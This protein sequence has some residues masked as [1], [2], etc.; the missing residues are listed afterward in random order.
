MRIIPPTNIDPLQTDANGSLNVNVVSSSAGGSATEAAG[1]D[2]V[3]NTTT[4]ALTAT[5]LSSFNG[6]TWDRVRS[7][8]IAVQST[9]AG[10]L[11]TL[12]LAVYNATPTTRTEGQGG[13]I[14][15][16]AR[17][18]LNTRN[19]ELPSYED[20]NALVARVEHQ[21]T[22]INCV[23]D[24]QVKASAGF[25]HC[26][27]VHCADVAPTVGSIIIYDNTAESGTIICI[28]QIDATTFFR[29]YT[30]L[31]D[32]VCTT[33]IYVGFTTTADVSVQLSY[34]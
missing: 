14:Q 5:H 22:G 31:F 11:N 18:A 26:V 20:Q 33:G 19:D 23:A 28:I 30:L 9:F 21:Y 17:G 1:A 25:L 29:P 24:T 16:S 10:L 32:R 34:R 4:R 8:L 27:T 2:A 3:S 15:A 6:T 7:G 13:P 12:P